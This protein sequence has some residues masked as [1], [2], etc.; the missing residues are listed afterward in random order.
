M[1]PRSPPPAL[2]ARLNSGAHL[3]I[4]LDVPHLRVRFSER[5]RIAH[6][7]ERMGAIVVRQFRI[8]AAVVVV[9]VVVIAVCDGSFLVGFAVVAWPC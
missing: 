6:E 5:V 1:G 9:A 7:V 3:R 2:S 8:V 4:R